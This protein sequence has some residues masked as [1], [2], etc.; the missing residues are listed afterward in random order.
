MGAPSAI[1]FLSFLEDVDEPGCTAKSSSET[2]KWCRLEVEQS[3]NNTNDRAQDIKL[4]KA[5]L[6]T[7]SVGT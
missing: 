1:V 5:Q 3:K 2:A 7:A 4:K 6:L